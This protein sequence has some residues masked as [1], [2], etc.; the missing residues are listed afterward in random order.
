MASTAGPVLCVFVQVPL[1]VYFL[2]LRLCIELDFH[3]QS[4]D[5]PR[6]ANGSLARPKLTPECVQCLA[7]PTPIFAFP[8]TSFC[9]LSQATRLCRRNQALSK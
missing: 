6:L 2:L 4:V 9:C 8:I 3:A 5:F 1:L 7:L